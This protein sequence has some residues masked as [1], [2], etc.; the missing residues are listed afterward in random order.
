MKKVL[1]YS[2]S[3]FLIFI[4]LVSCSSDNKTN[5]DVEAPTIEI[6]NPL[7]NA[8]IIYGTIVNIVAEADD[9]EEI[10]RVE[11]YINDSLVSMDSNYPYEYNW[12]TNNFVS[13]NMIYCTAYDTSDNQAISDSIFVTLITLTEIVFTD[14]FN[15]ANNWALSTS[16]DPEMGDTA[17]AEVT[18]GIL[19][20]SASQG[21]GGAFASALFNI[22]DSLVTLINSH[23]IEISTNIITCD[24]C[25]TPGCVIRLNSNQYIEIPW[26]Y[27]YNLKI[28]IL[29]DLQIIE[30]F[31]D[32][33]K[34]YEIDDFYLDFLN[35]VRFSASAC[36]PD[37]WASA[38]LQVDD[39]YISILLSE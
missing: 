21:G 17:V 37:F 31:K 7:N 2:L 3:F 32:D 20:L 10:E 22:P 28:K 18:Q 1:Q 9:N 19:N 36:S 34:I 39:F 35:S 23:N 29:F 13:D 30:I 33:V 25:P 8:E 11:F 14:L 5:P 24:F 4:I 12:D 16:Y 27:D 6:T 15:N 26:G 38:D